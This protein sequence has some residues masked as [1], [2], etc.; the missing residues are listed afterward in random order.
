[1]HTP[2]HA[3]WIYSIVD[4]TRKSA[5]SFSLSLDLEENPRDFDILP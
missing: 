5:L 2:A 3:T 4:I 1:M